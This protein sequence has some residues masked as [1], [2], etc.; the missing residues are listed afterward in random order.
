M[1]FIMLVYIALSILIFVA[2]TLFYVVIVIH[3]TPYEIAKHRNHLQQDALNVA[4]WIS[5]FR[6]M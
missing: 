6:L 1:E 4:G 5:L 2:V 3:Y